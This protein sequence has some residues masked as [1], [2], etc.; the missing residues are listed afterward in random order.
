MKIVV[1]KA[2]FRPPG[3]EAYDRL[4]PPECPP[5]PDVRY[6]LFRDVTVPAVDQG[7]EVRA[8]EFNDANNRLR[9]RHHKCRPDLLFPDAD[10][11][12]WLDGNIT[13]RVCPVEIVRRFGALPIAAI[14][15]GGRDCAYE[16]ATAMARKWRDNPS[17]IADQVMRYRKA[18]FPRKQ[19][20]AATGALL[21]AN[22]PLL[23]EVNADWWHEIER[24]S[25][26]DQIS[27]NYVLWRH[28]LEWTRLPGGWR[29]GGELFHRRPHLEP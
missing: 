26:R 15:H 6:V 9:A 20:L 28:G 2:V 5:H 23:H 24:G 27:F 19:G 10:W 17:V 4:H 8:A 22:R 16:E 21:R 1:Y 29:D 3:D 25:N 14:P 18:G 13:P 7:W 12:L 11:T